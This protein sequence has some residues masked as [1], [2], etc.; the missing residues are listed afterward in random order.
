MGSE[1]YCGRHAWLNSM[2][3]HVLSRGYARGTPRA[4][5]RPSRLQWS[6]DLSRGYVDRRAC[7]GLE[8]R[9]SMEPRSY[10]GDMSRGDVGGT[11]VLGLASMEPRSYLGIVPD[12][13][14]MDV[15]WA[16][17]WSPESYPGEMARGSSR[18]RIWFRLSRTTAIRVYSIHRE[19]SS[20]AS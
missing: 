18:P 14:S 2:E 1:P 15:Q 12:T 16:L 7:A 19:Q 8:L 4:R 20:A 13:V 9:A 6:P 3:S 11:T 17:Q 10:L 5:P